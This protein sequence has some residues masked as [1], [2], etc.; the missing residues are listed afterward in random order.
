MSHTVNVQSEDGYINTTVSDRNS[1]IFGLLSI[2]TESEMEG[3]VSTLF[4][5]TFFLI[6]V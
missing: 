5:E 3:R 2:L 1:T 6:F 4:F